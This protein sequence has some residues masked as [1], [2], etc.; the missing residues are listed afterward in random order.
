MGKLINFFEVDDDLPGLSPEKDRS[1][2]SR[3]WLSFSG[4]FSEF[5]DATAA[6]P[7]AAHL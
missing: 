6:R 2:Y 7:G 5:A 3:R 1:I 4:S